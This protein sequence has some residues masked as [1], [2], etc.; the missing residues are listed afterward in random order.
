M[1]RNDINH[2]Q[3]SLRLQHPGVTNPINII[4]QKPPLRPTNPINIIG[5][6]P[7]SW[8]EPFDRFDEVSEKETPGSEK[9]TPHLEKGRGVS[10]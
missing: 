4:G 3:L 10:K 2:Y 7:P 8:R 5:R 6:I 1:N 9:E